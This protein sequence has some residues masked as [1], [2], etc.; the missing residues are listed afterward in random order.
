MLIVCLVV[1]LHTTVSDLS[2]F[3]TMLIP[4]NVP[5][6]SS[7]RF[8]AMF[9]AVAVEFQC[10]LIFP[11]L[12]SFSNRLGSRFLVQII[13]LALVIRMLSVLADGANPR[14]LSYWTVVGRIDQFCIGMIAAR[15]YTASKLKK[16][17]VWWFLLAA[18][19]VSASLCWFNRAGGWP[20]VEGWKIA[21]P[22]I[23]GAMWAFFIIA[24]IPV[25][26]VMLGR[27]SWILAKLGE[28]SYSLYLIHFAVLYA[29][30]ERSFYLRPTGD[31]YYDALATTLLVALPVALIIAIL[32][33]Y[34]VELPFLQMR[35]KYIVS[36]EPKQSCGAG[37][38]AARI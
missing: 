24:Y 7:S 27:L 38:K 15:I 31:G 4:V 11:F 34:T 19:I 37:E 1:G 30:I 2:M 3:F 8:A 26:R 13:I 35:S 25:G 12:I 10:Y 5:G 33:Y 20:S 22:T 23:E 18:F 36:T 17:N 9:W 32:S 6:G 16:F 28:I 21:W 29:I 14:D